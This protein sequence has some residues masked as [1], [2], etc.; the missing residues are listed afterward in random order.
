MRAFCVE[1]LSRKFP[2]NCI[3][4]CGLPERRMKNELCHDYFST[5]LLSSVN[6]SRA[7]SFWLTSCCLPPN[8]RTAPLPLFICLLRWCFSPIKVMTTAAKFNGNPQ[9]LDDPVAEFRHLYKLFSLQISRL[10]YYF[11]FFLSSCSRN[12]SIKT[13]KYYLAPGFSLISLEI[14]GIWSGV[15]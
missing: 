8:I 5:K 14:S 15:T 6:M 4:C 10:K 9:N 2:C 12:Q 13:I 3:R 11:F 7:F 1:A